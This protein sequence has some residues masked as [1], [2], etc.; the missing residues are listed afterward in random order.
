M[1]RPVLAT[2]VIF[3]A[4]APIVDFVYPPR[5]PAC[6]EAIG[7]Q[8]GLCLDC[9]SRL[10]TFSDPFPG[11]GSIDA[12][13]AAAAYDDIARQLVLS[14]KHGR[15]VALAPFLARMIARILPDDRNAILVPVPLHRGRMW[16]RGYNQSAL[17][18]RELAKVEKGVLLV[19]GLERARRTP[20]LG[21]LNA[22]QRAAALAGS[23]RTNAKAVPS[24]ENRD[25]ILVDD[26]YTSGATARACAKVA[27]A[28]GARSVTAACFAKVVG[29][30]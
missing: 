14:F 5:C 4:V 23:I 6:G 27:R 18:A 1:S 10:Q 28:A 9:W 12:I 24:F 16:R 7:S 8:G 29:G 26:V 3:D 17:L 20:S 30:M 25:V 13:A 15:K 19:D 21:G 11:N 2:K 22:K